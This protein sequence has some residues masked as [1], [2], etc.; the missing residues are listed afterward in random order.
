MSSTFGV[1]FE[2]RSGAIIT[3]QADLAF[4]PLR[5]KAAASGGPVIPMSGASGAGIDQVLDMLLT[6]IGDGARHAVGV[7]GDNDSEQVQW[8][9][10]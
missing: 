8:S 10:L 4:R 9:P 1:E 5:W 2:N 7:D 3:A 6:A